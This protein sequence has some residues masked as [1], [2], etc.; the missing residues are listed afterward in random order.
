MNR[1]FKNIIG[2]HSLWLTLLT[3]AATTVQAAETRLIPLWPEGVPNLKTN[4]SG[5]KIVDG[6]ISNIHE[7]ALLVFRPDAANANGTAVIFCSGGGYVRIAVNTNG[8]A[9]TRR[10]NA[11]GVTVFSLKYRLSD[12]GHPAPLQDVLRAIRTVRARSAEFGVKN[13]RIGVMGASAGGHLAACAATL[14]DSPEGKTGAELDAVEA[15]PDFAILV[16]PVISMSEP[17][18]HKGSRDALVGKDASLDLREKLSVEK[19]VRRNSPPVFIAATMA[20]T[21]VPVENSL[22]FYQALR[23]AG[24]PAEMHVYAQGSHGNSLD[25][26][27]GPTAAWLTRCEEWLRFNGWLAKPD[28][29]K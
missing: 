20:D 6:R 9:I 29:A 15:R 22:H 24:V 25:P 19:H 28:S 3:V 26:K 27:Y 10:L 21:T 8:D 11:A 16:Y 12:Y 18:A 14:W 2:N 7:P 13:N 17:F 4:A 23:D 5:E 1:S